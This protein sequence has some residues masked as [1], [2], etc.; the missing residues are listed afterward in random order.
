MKSA[1]VAMLTCLMATAC[2]T[3]P[4]EPATPELQQLYSKPNVFESIPES[5]W[6]AES[7][8]AFAI[9]DANPKAPVHLLIIPKRRVP[10]LLQASPALL[11]E[12]FELLR[13]VVKQEGIE[14]SGF[15]TIINTHPDSRQSVYQL[16]IHVLGG[17]RMD[18]ADGFAAPTGAPAP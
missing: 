12:M 16:H 8:H 10:T 15:R 14:E 18:W 5:A 3:R 13:R 1:L 4:V 11:G 2:A 17:R 7:P 6:I 9:R